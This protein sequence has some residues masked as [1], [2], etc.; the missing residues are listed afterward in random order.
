MK[1]LIVSESGQ[2]MVE[3]VIILALIAIAAIVAVRALG[4]T[5]KQVFD[6]AEGELSGVM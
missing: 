6:Y 5:T 4:S 1:K 2:G 3:Y